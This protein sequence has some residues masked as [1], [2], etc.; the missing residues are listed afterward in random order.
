MGDGVGVAFAS[1]R[2]AG[3][4]PDPGS[5]AA[6]ASSLPLLRAPSKKQS[7]LSANLSYFHT[8]FGGRHSRFVHCFLIG[9][10]LSCLS[11]FV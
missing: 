7:I 4:A 6:F 11:C 1:C 3:R 5:H 8:L 2:V 10:I 9:E